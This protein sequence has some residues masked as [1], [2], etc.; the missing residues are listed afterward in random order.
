MKFSLP[1]ALLSAFAATTQAAETVQISDL[2]VDKHEDYLTQR[3]RIRSVEFTI[4]GFDA[5]NVRCAASP[6][7]TFPS[8]ILKCDDPKYRFVIAEGDEGSG[9]QFSIR[10]YYD[11]RTTR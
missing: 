9:L 8:D 6:T 11:N 1:L 10:L 5:K 2:Y 7:P 3:I 4:N